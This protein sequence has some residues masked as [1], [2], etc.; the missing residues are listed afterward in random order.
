ME[1]NDYDGGLISSKQFLVSDNSGQFDVPMKKK[2]NVTS[3][4]ATRNV[5]E[6][7]QTPLFN[8]KTKQFESD[9]E[10]PITSMRGDQAIEGAELT[11]WSPDKVENPQQ[12]NVGLFQS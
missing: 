6:V 4:F 12:L 3:K 8:I 11:T 5:K 1:F 10:S 9:Y 7:M 2:M